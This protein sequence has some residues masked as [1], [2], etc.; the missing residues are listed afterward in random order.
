MCVR[1]Q[2]L[3]RAFRGDLFSQRWLV[4]MNNADTFC[5]TS[6]AF[7]FFAVATLSG[8]SR[9]GEDSEMARDRLGESRKIGE[10]S[11]DLPCW[12]K[13]VKKF[14]EQLLM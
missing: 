10:D 11:C 4:I 12:G 2:L 5:Q 14:P 1:V 3:M 8:K 13:F 7:K 9:D 6:V